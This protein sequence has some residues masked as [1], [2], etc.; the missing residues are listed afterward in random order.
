MEDGDLPVSRQLIV[1]LVL[2][3]AYFNQ[4]LLWSL[5]FALRVDER[6]T[7]AS[8]FDAVALAI[9][10]A[11]LIATVV[12]LFGAKVHR[13]TDWMFL[14]LVVA[15]VMV[16]SLVGIKNGLSSTA[17]WLLA[18]NTLMMIHLSRGWLKKLMARRK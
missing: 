17:V 8:R 5:G 12:T 13:W 10:I 6:D 4:F 15:L 1:S 9:G 18:I 16:G 11:V 7:L 3:V 2:A 14:A